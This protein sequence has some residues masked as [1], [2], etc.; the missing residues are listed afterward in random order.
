MNV[1][2]YPSLPH[3]VCKQKALPDLVNVVLKQCH[4]LK[5][6]SVKFNMLKTPLNIHVYFISFY[7]L[8][9]TQTLLCVNT[10]IFFSLLLVSSS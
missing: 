3:T 6:I 8:L 7:S 1:Y 9:I 5:H 2:V 4:M 10:D